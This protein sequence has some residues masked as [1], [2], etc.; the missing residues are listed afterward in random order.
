MLV[1]SETIERFPK[2]AI[3]IPFSSFQE[4]PF[5]LEW[6][7]RLRDWWFSLIQIS[8]LRITCRNSW[9]EMKNHRISNSN[10]ILIFSIFSI[11]VLR[12]MRIIERRRRPR[13]FMRN[14]NEMENEIIS[15]Y[16]SIKLYHPP[17]TTSPI[18]MVW[19]MVCYK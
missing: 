8:A 7:F 9:N 17:T 18:A 12:T 6:Q 3:T 2:Q 19:Q 13:N 10:L 16:Y 11:F 14:N 1:H 5:S 15:R 4:Q